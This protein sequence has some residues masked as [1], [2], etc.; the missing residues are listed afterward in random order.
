MPAPALKLD[1][2]LLRAGMRIAVGVSG[3]ADSVALLRALHEQSRELGLVLHA[4]HLHHGLRGVEA[5]QDQVFVRDL[6]GQLNIPLH[7]ARVDVAAEAAARHETTEEAARRLRYAWF[8][9]LLSS[10]SLDAVATAHTLDDQAETVIG[11]FLRGAWTEGLSGIHPV[12]DFPEGRI[13]RP[14]LSTTRAEIEAWL[15]SF[16]QTWR[17]DSTNKHLTFTRNRI[18]HELLP[19]LETWNPQLR[20]H[21]A[22]MAELARDEEAWW[23]SEIEKLAPQLI[24]PGKPVRGGGRASGEDIAIDVTRFVQ[25][26]PAVQRRLLRHAAE[27]LGGALDFEATESLL[28]LATSG[29]AGQKRELGAGLQAERTHRELRLAG[30]VARVAKSASPEC[31]IPVPGR[32]DAPAFGLRVEVALTS[33]TFQLQEAVLRRW[34]AGDRVRLRHSSGPRKV[35]E[36]L[37]RMKIAGSDRAVWPVVDLGGTLIWMKGVEV[38]PVAGVEV[39]VTGLETA[40]G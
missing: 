22:H 17:E 29:R 8:R 37:E 2:G 13:V 4:A 28:T 25:L 1:L 21:M 23:H 35:K 14:L 24:L 38:E 34:K 32:I 11:K 39:T 10:Q 20:Q 40:S 6:A 16:H 15:H 36:V 31:M 3:G 7:E 18:R 27:M 26:V 33:A 5:D 19:L 9:E 12:L 30:A